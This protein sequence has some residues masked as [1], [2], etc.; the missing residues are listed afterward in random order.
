MQRVKNNHFPLKNAYQI[1]IKA[2]PYGGYG[3]YA[4]ED[5]PANSIIET[6]PTILVDEKKDYN[7]KSILNDYV[8]STMDK[9]DK[10]LIALGSCSIYNHQPEGKSNAEFDTIYDE[11]LNRYLVQM[12]SIKAIK[13]DTEITHNYGDEFWKDVKLG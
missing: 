1:E 4:K 12:K 2:S 11:K 5:I 3:V 7:K 6:C 8:F 9:N 10:E 13:K